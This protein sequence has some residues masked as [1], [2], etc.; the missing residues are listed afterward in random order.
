MIGRVALGLRITSA[1]SVNTSLNSS[2]K[3]TV[4]NVTDPDIWTTVFPEHSFA[5]D[6]L[7]FRSCEWLASWMTKLIF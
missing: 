6:L 4:I 5:R 3:N 2:N 1:N 7:Y